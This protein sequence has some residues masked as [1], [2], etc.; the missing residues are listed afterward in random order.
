MRAPEMLQLKTVKKAKWLAHQQKLIVCQFYPNNPFWVARPR[1]VS[2]MDR[3]I[4]PTSPSHIAQHVNDPK[5]LEGLRRWLE[6]Q[7]ASPYGAR[8]AW[9]Q[10]IDPLMTPEMRARRSKPIAHIT[11]LW[12][13]LRQPHRLGCILPEGLEIIIDQV[14]TIWTVEPITDFTYFPGF[15]K[16]YDFDDR[17]EYSRLR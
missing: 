13:A 8:T 4:E 10:N 16:R 17:I 5:A 15:W 6:I 1:F 9:I 11:H 12:E 3:P 7:S 2:A 14:K